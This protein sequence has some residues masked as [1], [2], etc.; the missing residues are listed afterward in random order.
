MALKP[1]VFKF[2]FVSSITHTDA[3]HIHASSTLVLY[4]IMLTT[5][6]EHSVPSHTH[7][8]CILIS[9]CVVMQIVM[10][11]EV[12]KVDGATPGASLVKEELRI[13]GDVDT[14]VFRQYFYSGV[15]TPKC[16]LL[17]LLALVLVTGTVLLLA[18]LFVFDTLA[19]TLLALHTVQVAFSQHPWLHF[20]VRLNKSHNLGLD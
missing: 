9:Q 19:G 18:W 7:S 10:P 20:A 3:H 17:F 6:A 4:H 8:F 2:A 12:K 14:D 13:R 15:A 16:L 11:L 1:V 5:F